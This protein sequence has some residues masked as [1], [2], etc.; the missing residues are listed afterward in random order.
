MKQTNSYIRQAKKYYEI[1]IEKLKDA[2][3]NGD[4]TKAVDACAKGWLAVILATNALFVKSGVEPKQ[5]PRAHRGRTY[6]LTKYGT[7][8]LRRIFGSAYAVLHIDG[9][10]ERLIDYV[11]IHETL[12][13]IKEYISKVEEL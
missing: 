11:R 3:K 5:L 12:D 2:E 7:R 4:E 10:Y 9:Y 1:A 6:M 8:E 13:D